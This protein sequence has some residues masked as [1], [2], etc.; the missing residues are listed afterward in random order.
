[1]LLAAMI[2]TVD[3]SK[4]EAGSLLNLSV[5]GGSAYAQSE[6][7]YGNKRDGKCTYCNSGYYVIKIQC[8]DG[9]ASCYD[10]PCTN[11]YC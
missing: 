3:I 7:G 5:I 10:T 6:G 2:Y 4:S 11:G 1:M 9:K 8:Y